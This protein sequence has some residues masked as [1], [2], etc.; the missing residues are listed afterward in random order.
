MN[1]ADLTALGRGDW[2]AWSFLCAL[3]RSRQ[4]LL[5]HPEGWREGVE[6]ATNPGGT[7][8]IASWDRAYRGLFAAGA[9]ALRADVRHAARPAAEGAAAR[10]DQAGRSRQCVA[11]GALHRRA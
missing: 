9:R 2:R 4:P 3:H 6:D 1:A 5:L 10:R 11:E 8:F 7:G